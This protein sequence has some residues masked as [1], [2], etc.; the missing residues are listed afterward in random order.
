MKSAEPKSA[1]A[2]RNCALAQYSADVAS[3]EGRVMAEFE[4]VKHTVPNMYRNLRHFS[5]DEISKRVESKERTTHKCKRPA[6]KIHARFVTIFEKIGKDFPASPIY[7]V[8][9]K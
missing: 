5:T 2:F 1:P 9:N 4:L 7:R 3:S 6:L 8:L